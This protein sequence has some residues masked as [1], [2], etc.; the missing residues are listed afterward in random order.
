MKPPPKGWPRISSTVIYDD[1]KAAIDWLCKAFGFEV[2]L[3]VEG[4]GGTIEHSELTFGEGLIMVGGPKPRF[5][6]YQSPGKSGGHNTQ[7][8]MVYVDDVKAH[9]ERARAAGARIIDEV[10]THDYGEEYWADL[11]YGCEDVG[12]HHGWFTQRLR[13]Q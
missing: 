8:L 6:Q 5:P 2:Q 11:S 13:G 3:K 4:D 1:P 9:C 12:G 7:S 10:S